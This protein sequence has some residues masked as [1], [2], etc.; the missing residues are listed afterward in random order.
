M[1]NIHSGS[2]ITAPSTVPDGG[3]TL[4]LLGVALVGVTGL[5]RK[6]AV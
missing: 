5:K 4:V 2:E 3:S 6:L 1:L